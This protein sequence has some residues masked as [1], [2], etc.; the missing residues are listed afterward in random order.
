V[1]GVF[2]AGYTIDEAM[3]NAVKVLE[4]AAEDWSDLSG[5]RFPRHHR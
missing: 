5:E 2:T 1:P 3:R 4:F